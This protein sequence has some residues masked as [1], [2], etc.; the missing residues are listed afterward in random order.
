MTSPNTVEA[1]DASAARESGGA[2]EVAD[3]TAIG[4]ETG[5]D[6]LDSCDSIV[7]IHLAEFVVVAPKVVGVTTVDMSAD[8]GSWD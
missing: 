8:G 1:V 3:V 7:S 5:D 6:W 4:G 2:F